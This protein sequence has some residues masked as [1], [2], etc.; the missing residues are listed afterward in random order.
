MVSPDDI[1]AGPE[2][3]AREAWLRVALEATKI[4][5]W[6]WRIQENESSWDAGMLHIFGRAKAPSTRAE[7]LSL[8]HP[9]DRCRANERIAQSLKSLKTGIY[10]PWEYRILRPDGSV[11][12]VQS[13]GAVLLGAGQ[14][15][16]RIVGGLIDVTER[17]ELEEQ[18]QALQRMEAVGQLAA[19]V[20][21]NF[22][23]MLAVIL[24]A[25]EMAQEA[26]DE[27]ILSALQD[28]EHAAHRAAEMVRDLA[29]FARRPD[30]VASR[31][32]PRDVVAITA[33][34]VE[35]CR[36][37]FGA[38]VMLRFDGPSERPWVLVADGQ[39]EQTLV[40]LLINARDAVQGV[41][42]DGPAIEVTIEQLP[43]GHSAIPSALREGTPA[44][45]VVCIAVRDWGAGMDEAVRGRIFEPFFTTKEVGHGTGLGLSTAY[46]TVTGHGGA[47]TCESTRGVG[48]ILRVFLPAHPAPHEAIA[49]SAP[50][51]GPGLRKRRCILI[52]DDDEAVGRAT[53]RVLSSRGD[54]T[55]V[56]R[57]A[58]AAIRFLG[59]RRDVDV[60]VLDCEMPGT[61][62]PDAL[63][64]LRAASPQT[65]VL[66]FSGTALPASASVADGFLAKPA[67]PRRLLA[68]IDRALGG[69]P[70]GAPGDRE[71]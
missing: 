35:L 8:I 62:G 6:E 57:S 40:N 43:E 24:P 61:S 60:I 32:Q 37:M 30:P 23:N 31:M 16:E 14:R 4:G 50:R 45:G 7:Y 59:S 22:N 28:A 67:E 52:V 3:E 66:Y 58:E 42:H 20:A 70:G 27:P 26:V 69:A 17:H 5:F 15:P 11:R 9:A 34:A 53:G 48:T 46:A 36:R 47:I 38:H 2:Q 29:C 64:A 39:I 51:E 49:P 65:K 55:S 10:D 71:A 68:A 33:H 1:E 19:G 63:A 18:R 54:E 44:G 13:L 41:Q 21:H 25:V 12:W 56:V